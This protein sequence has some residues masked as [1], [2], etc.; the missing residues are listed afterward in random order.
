MSFS[1]SGYVSVSLKNQVL[2]SCKLTKHKNSKNSFL[3][4]SYPDE[5]N[6][7]ID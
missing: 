4:L 2:F 7:G 5:I 6:A 3:S 1:F